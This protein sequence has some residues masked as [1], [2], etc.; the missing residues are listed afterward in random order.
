MKIYP[1]NDIIR[2]IYVGDMFWFKGN[3]ILS[4]G[5]CIL[6]S[7]HIMNNCDYKLLFTFTVLNSETC[8][9]YNERGV[10]RSLKRGNLKP[11]HQ[12]R[13]ENTVQD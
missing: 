11:I 2:N 9:N 5:E 12:Q 8:W 10:L 13:Y 6:T 3:E 7:I 4:E 1:Q